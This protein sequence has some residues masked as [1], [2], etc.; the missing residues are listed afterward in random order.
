[1]PTVA[2]RTRRHTP[3][4]RWLCVAQRSPLRM[5]G[6]HDTQMRDLD[7]P[8]AG[9]DVDTLTV[10]L[11]AYVVSE[12]RDTDVTP[13]IYPPRDAGR[14]WKR[15][16]HG[17]LG[18]MAV[19]VVVDRQNPSVREPEAPVGRHVADAL[20][21]PLGVVLLHPQVE[22]GLRVLERGEDFDVEQLGAHRL[23]QALDL[24]R[25]RR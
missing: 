12:T 24:P 9:D 7:E 4:C 17:L 3:R 14:G 10:E 23:V 19:E 21:R 2:A 11:P 20:V 8:A 15:G 1:M 25:R 5:R 18:R 22:S 16:R 13:R 6:D